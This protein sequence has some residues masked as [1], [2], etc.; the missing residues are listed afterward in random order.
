LQKL[1]HE[2]RD[3]FKQQGINRSDLQIEQ[4]SQ[5]LEK[6]M[7]RSAKKIVKQYEKQMGITQKKWY[8]IWK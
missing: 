8:E 7:N 4:L 5:R 3:Y 6:R 2:L 1:E